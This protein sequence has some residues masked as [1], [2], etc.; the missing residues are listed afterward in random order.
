MCATCGKKIL[1]V[2]N[3]AHAVILAGQLVLL[4]AKYKL[5]TVDLSKIL[6]LMK[7]NCRRGDKEIVPQ[8]LSE[9]RRS[10]FN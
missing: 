2:K 1:E 9:G 4:G 7:W 3:R 10:P 5:D 6:T 8:D